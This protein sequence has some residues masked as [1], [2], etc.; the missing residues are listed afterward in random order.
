MGGHGTIGPGVGMGMKELTRGPEPPRP[1]QQD[2]SR[3]PESKYS[4]RQQEEGS[5]P[6]PVPRRHLQ[7]CPAPA[8]PLL[9]PHPRLLKLLSLPAPA[10]LFWE[11]GA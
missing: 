2:C 7:P 10:G 4:S 8:Q 11:L 3:I 1:K 9:P 6:P 5:G